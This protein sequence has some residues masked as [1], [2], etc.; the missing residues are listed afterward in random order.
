MEF[1]ATELSVCD[2]QVF[3]HWRDMTVWKERSSTTILTAV[4]KGGEFVRTAGVS[5]KK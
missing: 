2:P 5:S 4:L 1:E 3:H